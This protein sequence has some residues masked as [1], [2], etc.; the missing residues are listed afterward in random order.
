MKLE[1]YTNL[2][3][4]SGMNEIIGDSSRKTDENALGEKIVIGLGEGLSSAITMYLLKIQKMDIIA[5]TILIPGQ[6]E[7]SI[8]EI[9]SLCTRLSV[10]H[11]LVDGTSE[12][13]EVVNNHWIEKRMSGKNIDYR[14]L[15]ETFVMD[16]L[17][18]KFVELDGD[19]LATGHYAKMAGKAIQRASDEE[20]DQSLY[21]ARLPEKI[22]AKLLLPLS[23]LRVSEV[24][25]IAD[26]F[27]IAKKEKAI[28]PPEFDPE[29]IPQSIL[30]KMII[31]DQ[32]T[33]ET[34]KI[35][36]RN[37]VIPSKEDLTSPFDGFVLTQEGFKACLIRPKNLNGFLIEFKGPAMVKE[38]EILSV[39]KKNIKNSKVYL[40]GECY[41]V[42][43]EE[44][45]SE[46]SHLSGF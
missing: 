18:R 9:K 2:N 22:R 20:H 7:S 34:T 43:G 26:N 31:K 38:G 42:K 11:L 21:V 33:L 16:L 30:N 24:K 27:G 15:K 23:D 19:R 17:Y 14:L 29:T 13:E 5:V 40:S 41:V 46:V 10:P 6:S 4:N 1:P 35:W 39:I 3:Y 36:L 37:C 28:M 25:K 12:F 44:S 8:Q 45:D 32:E